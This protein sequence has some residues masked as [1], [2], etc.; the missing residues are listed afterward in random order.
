M[1]TDADAGHAQLRWRLS[2][3]QFE[4]NMLLDFIFLC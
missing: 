2:L 1:T 4:H 3:Q